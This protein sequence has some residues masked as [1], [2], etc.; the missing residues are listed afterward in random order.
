MVMSVGVRTIPLRR[1]TTRSSEGLCAD[2]P[3]HGPVFAYAPFR[4]EI[5]SQPT[6]CACFSQTLAQLQARAQ[7]TELS[8]AGATTQRVA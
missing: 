3:C 1:P 4:L 2:R 7:A 6:N 8:K 5:Q